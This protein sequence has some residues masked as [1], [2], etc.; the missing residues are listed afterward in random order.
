MTAGAF[1]EKAVPMDIPTR[2]IPQGLA[3][4]GATPHRSPLAFAR[5]PSVAALALQAPVPTVPAADEAPGGNT[6]PGK[7]ANS[8]CCG[9]ASRKEM[10]G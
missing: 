3:G 1:V 9:H 7:R 4:N 2:I 10:Y 5:R 6:V 8:P